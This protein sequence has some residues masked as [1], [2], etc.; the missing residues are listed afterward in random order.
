MNISG[1]LKVSGNS[2]GVQKTS[3]SYWYQYLTT[4]FNPDITPPEE[5]T[6]L[7][8]SRWLEAGAR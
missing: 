2:P 5:P 8:I 4:D 6:P 7:A 3:L 1:S